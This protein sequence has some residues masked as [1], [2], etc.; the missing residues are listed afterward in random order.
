MVCEGLYKKSPFGREKVGFWLSAHRFLDG[1]CVKVDLWLDGK[2]VAVYI[3]C[4]SLDF[5]SLLRG[6]KLAV[7]HCV[8]VSLTGTTVA[9]SFVHW[10]LVGD[11]FCTINTHS[12]TFLMGMGPL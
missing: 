6:V 7:V 9:M 1:G 4:N 5:I 3:S 8:R 2:L 11:W 12:V 10:S